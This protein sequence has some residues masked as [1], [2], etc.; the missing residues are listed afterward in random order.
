MRTFQLAVCIMHGSILPEHLQN[1]F[2]ASLFSYFTARAI[3]KAA[4]C[5]SQMCGDCNLQKAFAQGF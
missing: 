2:D 3:E 4:L 5:Y 1:T